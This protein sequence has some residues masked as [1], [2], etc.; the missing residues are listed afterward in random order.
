MLGIKAGSSD[1]YDMVSMLVLSCES[2]FTDN[3]V[4]L[5][6]Q[7]ALKIPQLFTILFANSFD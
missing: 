2:T 3:F 1:C 7:C 5:I 6:A 4:R